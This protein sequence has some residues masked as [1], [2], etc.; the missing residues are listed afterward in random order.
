[1]TNSEVSLGEGVTGAQRDG[2]S[3]WMLKKTEWETTSQA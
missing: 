2:S 1:M 3:T